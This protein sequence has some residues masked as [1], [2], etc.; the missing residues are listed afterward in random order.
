MRQHDGEPVNE[1]GET[2]LV[3]DDKPENLRL[4]D[5]L[6]SEQGYAVRVA[7]A[8]AQ[9]LESIACE[10]PDLVLLDIRMPGMDGYQVCERLKSDESTRDIPVIFL[11]AAKDPIDKVKAFGVGGVDYVTKPFEAG[12]VLARVRSHL[13]T[14][15]LRRQLRR[16]NRLLEKR[17]R[18]RTADLTRA[19]ESLRREMAQHQQAEQEK[20][21][22]QEQLLFA[23][24]ME[25]VGQLAGGVAH[26]FNNLLTV[27]KVS[28]EMLRGELP[29]G[30]P[31]ELLQGIE[32]AADQASGVTRSLLTF[33]HRLRPD[34][35][36]VDLCEIIDRAV[37]LLNRLLPASVTL[38]VQEGCARPLLV[39]AD[40]TQLQ[41]V[42]INLAINARDAMPNGGQLRIV[43]GTTADP[44]LGPATPLF[45]VC[46]TGNG[47]LPQNR[48][49]IFEPFFTTKE[50]SQG[51]GLGLAIVHSIVQEHGGRIDV[52]SVVLPPA[53]K[54]EASG[55]TTT[56]YAPPLGR[57]ELILVA[58]DNEPLRKLVLLMMQRL[59]YEVMAV[60]NGNEL[61]DCYA[62]NAGRVRLLILDVDL[63]GR[64][65]LDCLEQIR[66]RDQQTPVIVATG[67]IDE[68][69]KDVLDSRTVLLR[70]PFPTAQL[71]E[72]AGRLL[73]HGQPQDQVC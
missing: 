51:T 52:D 60:G 16:A 24:K 42:A 45:Q 65:G 34:K 39:D 46:D 41:Q 44:D 50:R 53:A 47:I 30:E 7:T 12:E 40:H 28:A 23:Q 22:L 70:K 15:R 6:L 29:A 69:P 2:I 63:P 35:A 48:A 14:N 54:E 18:E 21:S 9:A 25:A 8:G 56:A 55:E 57:G 3:V 31:R 36:C 64:S 5:A 71:R 59:G 49:R 72:V 27:I 43:V 20:T 26:D 19:N 61:L 11:S 37:K 4:L 32:R 67:S 73:S 33:S 66:T 68:D 38:T 10:P 62:R 17:V 13:T 58:E 1:S